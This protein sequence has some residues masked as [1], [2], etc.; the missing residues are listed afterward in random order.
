[1]SSPTTTL[2]DGPAEAEAVADTAMISP[3]TKA[4]AEVAGAAAIAWRRRFGMEIWVE[5]TA[6][7]LR[8]AIGCLPLEL[9]EMAADYAVVPGVRFS[10]QFLRLAQKACE[11]NSSECLDCQQRNSSECP[12]CRVVFTDGG[13][14]AEFVQ[15]GEDCKDHAILVLGSQPLQCFRFGS[16]GE[17]KVWH[18]SLHTK[19]MW[20]VGVSDFKIAAL[21]AA[22]RRYPA[23]T[24]ML[25]A[26]GDYGYDPD[27]HGCNFE[28]LDRNRNLWPGR[29]RIGPVHHEEEFVYD[30][31]ITCVRSSRSV[32]AA[33]ERCIRVH[34]GDTISNVGF[35]RLGNDL[36]NFDNL[37]PAVRLRDGSVT[38]L[39]DPPTPDTPT[40]DPPPR[41]N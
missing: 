19:E 13:T 27:G 4:E 37:V 8:D 16:D 15:P 29:F 30:V 21:S 2:P 5:Q 34:H 17:S 36:P 33:V 28:Q 31:T 11:K 9:A 40:Q 7:A 1:M 39:P 35:C 3:T 41:S 10:T 25:F 14:R 18:L 20:G 23:G 22:S 6:L 26:D 12:D 32:F 24:Y 38:I